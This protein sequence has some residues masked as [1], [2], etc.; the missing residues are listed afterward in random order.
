[1]YSCLKYYSPQYLFINGFARAPS[2][3]LEKT[4]GDKSVLIIFG[5]DFLR[6]SW[7]SFTNTYSDTFSNCM[8]SVSV[9]GSNKSMMDMQDSSS[10]GLTRASIFSTW[11]LLNF[12]ISYRPYNLG[13]VHSRPEYLM[14]R[15]IAG[16][17]L[18]YYNMEV[19]IVM[20]FPLSL[21]TNDPL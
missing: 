9:T 10:N 17:S 18:P 15:I 3:D 19:V 12:N 7:H 16:L 21:K 8:I 5:T 6:I 13:L 14:H 20:G 4:P 1:V 11:M 2:M